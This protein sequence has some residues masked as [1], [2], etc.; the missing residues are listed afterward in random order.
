MQ[1]CA[2][3]KSLQSNT[4]RVPIVLTLCPARIIIYLA[5]FLFLL[6]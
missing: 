5:P 2:N 1:R 6:Y 3:I 4:H